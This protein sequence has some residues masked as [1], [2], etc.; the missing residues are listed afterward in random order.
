MERKFLMCAYLM[1]MM[2]VVFEMSKTLYWWQ[3][4]VLCVLHTKWNIRGRRT[5]IIWSFRHLWNLL[6]FPY[7]Q[8]KITTFVEIGP[9]RLRPRQSGKSLFVRLLPLARPRGVHGC[10]WF[11]HLMCRV[12]LFSCACFQEPHSLQAV[13][14]GGKILE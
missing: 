8:D 13:A 11:C 10:P 1:C 2:Q 4:V 3:S 7:R 9:E 12:C 5:M 14:K 6:S